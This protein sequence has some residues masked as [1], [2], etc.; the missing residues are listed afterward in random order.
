MESGEHDFAG[1]LLYPPPECDIIGG[2]VVVGPIN[3]AINGGVVEFG[4]EYRA[5]PVLDT[6]FDSCDCQN[7]DEGN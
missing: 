7:E 2:A 1:S 4:V 6:I 3:Q 5:T